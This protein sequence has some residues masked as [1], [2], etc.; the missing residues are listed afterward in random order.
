MRPPEQRARREAAWD[1][2]VGALL[3]AGAAVLLADTFTFASSPFTT[4]SPRVL[5]RLV[6]VLL[7]PLAGALLVRG[8]VRWRRAA[9]A[10]GRGEPLGVLLWRYRNVPAAFAL[11][12][13]FVALMPGLGFRLAGSGFL[14]ALLVV[15]GGAPPRRWPLLAGYAV[16]ITLGLYY[17]FQAALRVFLPAGDWL[18]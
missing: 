6:L 11:F 12:G 13:A 10:A 8:A 9:A 14:V 1:A 5:P 17:F 15:T 18:S 2:G 4:L 7:L 3:L 16:A